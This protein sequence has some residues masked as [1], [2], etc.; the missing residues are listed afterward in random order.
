[1]FELPGADWGRGVEPSTVFNPPN[2]LSN[3]VLGVSYIH[4]NFG[5]APTIEK[6]NPQLTFHNSNT[7][8][9]DNN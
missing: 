1:M 5:R 6:F 8:Y 7:I 4:H 2:T 9:H 3:Y